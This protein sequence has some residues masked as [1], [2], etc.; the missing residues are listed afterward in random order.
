MLQWTSLVPRLRGRGEPGYEANAC[1]NGLASYPDSQVGGSLGYEAN[2]CYNGL[3][4]YPGSQA[5]GSL[6][7]RLMRVRMD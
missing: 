7:T 5:G 2:A 6:G 3:A 4:S 1:Y